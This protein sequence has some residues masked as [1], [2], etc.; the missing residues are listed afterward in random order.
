M[1][2]FDLP[3]TGLPLLLHVLARDGGGGGGGGLYGGG[4][5][6]YGGGGDLYG[7]GG[8]AQPPHRPHPQTPLRHITFVL[9]L[10]PSEHFALRHSFK[11]IVSHHP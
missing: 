4:G 1:H 5:G 10:P 8:G 9:Q 2:V 3:D 6:L 11:P 7:G